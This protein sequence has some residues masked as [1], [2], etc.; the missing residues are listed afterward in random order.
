MRGT[1]R[2]PGWG[3][4]LLAAAIVVAWLFRVIDLPLKPL[5]SDESVNGWFTLRL[6]WPAGTFEGVS[7]GYY[8]YRASDYHGPFLYYV[9][10]V[11]FWLLGPS[12]TSLRLG[13]AITGVVGVGAVALLRRPLG[14]V[15]IAAAAVMIA[16]QPMDV[17]FARTVIHEVYLVTFSLVFV[18]AGWAWIERG[19]MHRACLS[20]LGLAV[21]FANKET[22]LISLVCVAAA[23]AIVWLLLPW[24]RPNDADGTGSSRRTIV[25]DAMDRWRDIL[26]ALVCFWFVMILFFS[27]FF[28]YW[29]GVEGIFT[30]Y[31]YWTEYG[32]TG[33]NQKKEFAYWLQYWPFLWPAVLAGVAELS[34]GLARREKVTVFLGVWLALSFGVYSAIPYKTP[35]CLLN[36]TLPLALLAGCG[37]ARAW[38]ATSRWR[39]AGA[40]VIGVWLAMA[41]MLGR[42]SWTY[43][44]QQYDDP[45]VLFVYVQTQRNYMG[46]IELLWT[47]DEEG[48]HDGDLNVVAIDAKNPLRWYLYTRGWNP[49]N[50]RFY[51]GYPGD[52]K[53]WEGWRDRADIFV[54]R[55]S[56]KKRLQRELGDGYEVQTFPT[57]PGRK[58]TLFVPVHLW[59]PL[60][61]GAADASGEDSTGS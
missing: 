39:W 50:F 2:E 23:A 46:L 51:K 33:R 18:G 14:L 35:W 11:M 37:V 40:L 45:D 54:C 34:V 57:R 59:Q 1:Q 28:T 29:E 19:G 52:E 25:R 3:W 30:T 6:L 32:V 13:T 42:S 24:L 17:Y 10:L 15:A 8:H 31:K 49:S 22:A 48:G 41:G 36:V 60:F 27:S 43:N 55:D 38:R 5:H 7:T 26:A 16:V 20:A 4:L 58:V 53:D 56:H 12:D 47:L 9:N 44:F 21:M 61:G